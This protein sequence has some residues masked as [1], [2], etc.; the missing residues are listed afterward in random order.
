MGKCNFFFM[1]KQYVYSPFWFHRIEIGPYN[2]N[3][4]A[5]HT[6]IFTTKMPFTSQRVGW[7]LTTREVL[8]I[9]KIVI[10]VVYIWKLTWRNWLD[11]GLITNRYVFQIKMVDKKLTELDDF[12]SS[13]EPLQPNLAKLCCMKI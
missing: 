4:L 7:K 6:S 10:G 11:F 9:F 1:C 5:K 12:V 8:K 3:F 2:W 13:L